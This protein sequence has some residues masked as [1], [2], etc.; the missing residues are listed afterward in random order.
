MSSKGKINI[1][2]WVLSALIVISVLLPVCISL[3]KRNTDK[4]DNDII[5]DVNS[6]I[7]D[8][9]IE[10]EQNSMTINLLSGEIVAT[11]KIDNVFVNVNGY[12]CQNLQYTQSLNTEG[13]YVIT[14]T[15]NSGLLNTCF[16]SD[17]KITA[18]IYVEYENRSH[19][20]ASKDIDVISSWSPTR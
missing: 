14:I 5:T 15:P 9:S 16:D 7:V 4:T 20:V 19:K 6:D 13:Y 8:Y 10:F 12:G 3:G 2:I 17:A 11:E 1:L 18:D